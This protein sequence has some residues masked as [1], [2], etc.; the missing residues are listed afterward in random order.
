M[1]PQPQFR[2]RNPKPRRYEVLYGNLVV[3]PLKG[4][5]LM[6]KNIGSYRMDLHYEDGAE[7]RYIT[8]WPNWPNQQVVIDNIPHNKLLSLSWYTL[9]YPNHGSS[10]VEDYFYYG[11]E[12]KV[13]IS[14]ISD[15][16][17]YALLP[18]I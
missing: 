4:G 18:I 1:A 17:L 13:Y 12:Q 8:L 15:T 6:I 11:P 3:R 7:S 14:V 10:V 2:V 9:E 5:K 16:R